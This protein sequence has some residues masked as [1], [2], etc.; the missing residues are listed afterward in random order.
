MVTKGA[1]AGGMGSLHHSDHHREG[2]HRPLRRPR[3][4]RVDARG[5]GRGDRHLV[6]GGHRLE[7]AA[8]GGDLKPRIMLIKNAKGKVA[9]PRQ[10]PRGALLPVGRRHPL[11]RERRRGQGR[12]RAGAHPARILEDARHHRR[13][14]AR[15]R[16]VRG[17]PSPRISPSSARSTAASN[18]ARTTRPSAASSWCRPRTGRRAGRVPD[19]QGQAHQRAGRRFRPEGRSADGRQSRAA[20]HPARDGRRGAGELSHQRDPGGLSSPGRAHQ[21]QAHRGDRPPDAAE[22]RDRRSRRDHAA[23]PASRSTAPSSTRRTPRP[24]RRGCKPATARPVLQ[25]ITKASLQTNS[26]IS[27]ASFQET[28]RVLTEAAVSGRIDVLSG[29]QGE[30]HRRPPHPGRHRQR[31]GALAPDRR[32]AR[33]RAGGQRAAG[34]GEEAVPPR[35]ARRSPDQLPD[36]RT[37]EKGPLHR[38]LFRPAFP[39]RHGDFLLRPWPRPN[40]PR[41]LGK[42]PLAGPYPA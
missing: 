17:A 13:S 15:R 30:R 34:P 16:A 20:R 14:A 11:G 12:R 28:T 3:R 26:F 4:G 39:G 21:R 29:P 35:K 2:R 8:K 36:S 31:H 27:A 41:D 37:T 10:R 18:S 5:G 40:P 32:R 7:A 23:S 25:G 24:R 6:Q 1:A 38:P 22:G 19:P 42:T 33:P 9:D